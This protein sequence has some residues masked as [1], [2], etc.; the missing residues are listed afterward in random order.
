M[1]NAIFYKE[2]IKTKWIA[3]LSFLSLFGLS[4]F[5]IYNL[6][7]MIEIKGAVHIW[8]VIIHRVARFITKMCYIP[9]SIVI[10]CGIL[11]FVP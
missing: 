7:R 10:V 5:L 1:I 2:W 11:R 9:L 6:Y 8:E 4:T 3:I